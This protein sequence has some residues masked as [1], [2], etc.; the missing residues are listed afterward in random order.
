MTNNAN[1]PATNH[2]WT[3]QHY[4]KG[5]LKGTEL[6]YESNA[7]PGLK[8]GEVLIKTLL[9]SLDPSNRIWLSEEK[10]YLPQ[11]QIGDVMRGQRL[12]EGTPLTYAYYHQVKRGRTSKRM[13]YRDP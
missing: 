12:R 11:L 6:A 9:L 4:A 10:D 7:L 13:K 5:D 2:I 3:I 1:I 8:E